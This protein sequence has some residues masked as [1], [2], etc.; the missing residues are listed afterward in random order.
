M[1]GEGLQVVPEP[2]DPCP[3]P[4]KCQGGDIVA[5]LESRERYSV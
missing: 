1:G 4:H 2:P 3:S 5:A